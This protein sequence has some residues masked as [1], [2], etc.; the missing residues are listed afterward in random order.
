MKKKYE[1]IT[2]RHSVEIQCLHQTC[3]VEVSDLVQ[4]YSQ[5]SRASVYRHAMLPLNSETPEDKRTQNTGRPRLLSVRGG[6]KVTREIPRQRKQ[7]GSFTSKRIQTSSGHTDVSNRTVRR[8]LNRSNYGYLRTR[9]KGVLTAEDVKARLKWARKIR[10]TW[11][12]GSEKL[13][14]EGICFYLDGTGFVYKSNPF[15]QASS[16]KAREWRRPDEA[17]SREC[18]AKGSKEGNKQ[19]KFMVCVS[20]G[21][22]AVKCECYDGRINSDKFVS[23]LNE[24]LDDAFQKSCNPEARRFLMDGC[25]VQNSKVCRDRLDQLNAK[26]VH[27]PARSPDLNPIENVFNLVGVALSEQTIERQVTRET[28]DEFEARIVDLI[29]S[30]PSADIDKIIDTMPKRIDLIIEAKGQRIRY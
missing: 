13:W 19:I 5:Y 15:D 14:K 26:I 3:G 22:G 20:Y 21:K 17:L 10:R 4:R 23:F 29:M 12:D 11:P 6:R 28:E 8:T 24:H 25:P 1:K 27:I 9:R 16:P 30:F 18:T 2:L 7:A